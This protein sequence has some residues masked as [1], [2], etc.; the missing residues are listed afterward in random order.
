MHDRIHL[1][2]VASSQLARR[3]P[4]TFLFRFTS[5]DSGWLVVSYTDQGGDDGK[6]KISHCLIE[7]QD[8]RLVICFQRGDMQTQPLTFESIHE[9]VHTCVPLKTLWPD[10]PKEQAFP[11]GKRRM[12]SSPQK[13]KDMA[14]GTPV[15]FAGGMVRKTGVGKIHI[16][17]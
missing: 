9:L 7:P 3:L 2:S 5:K 12:S 15:T 13:Q 16:D 17:G 14:P 8:G 11:M 6:Q 10:T 4:G 1:L